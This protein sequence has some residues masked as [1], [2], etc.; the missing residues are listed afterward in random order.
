MQSQFAGISLATCGNA[1]NLKRLAAGLIV[2]PLILSG[3]AF[4]QESANQPFRPS[5]LSK[6]SGQAIGTSPTKAADSD[7]ADAVDAALRSDKVVRY[8]DIR[9]DTASGVVTLSGVVSS[10]FQSIRA[11]QIASTVDG[12]KA[13]NNHLMIIALS[14]AVSGK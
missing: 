2:A 12:V 6:T 8:E 10:A 9:V 5:Q 1:M 3:A 14:S 13:V 4:A 7:I 11:Q